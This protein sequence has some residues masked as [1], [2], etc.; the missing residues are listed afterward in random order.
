MSMHC[1]RLFALGAAFLVPRALVAACPTW[2]ALQL[3]G[4][5]DALQLILILLALRLVRDRQRAMEAWPWWRLTHSSRSSGAG[6]TLCILGLC[7][8]TQ[9]AIT[10]DRWGE[11]VPTFVSL[12]TLGSLLAVSSFRLAT[13]DRRRRSPGGVLD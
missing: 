3:P 11:L 4:I 8:S 5:R 10:W 1:W 13:A 6:A 7:T 2:S 9:Y 12:F